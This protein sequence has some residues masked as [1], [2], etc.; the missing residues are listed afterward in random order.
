MR[1]DELDTQEE[2][3]PGFAASPANDRRILTFGV[4]YKPIPQVVVKVDFQ[5]VRDEAG[6]AL[7][8]FHAALGFLF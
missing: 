1:L 2:V 3:P 4:S 7:D 6:T 8:E 5:D